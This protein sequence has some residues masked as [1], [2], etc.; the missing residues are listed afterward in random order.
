[1]NKLLLC[2]RNFLN[3]KGFHEGTS[4]HC[5]VGV[6]DCRIWYKQKEFNG[7]NKKQALIALAEDTC[8]ATR[9]PLLYGDACGY[10]LASLLIL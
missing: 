5:Y 9:S 6:T 7:E 10:C 8:K 3:V 2:L 1:M 4:K